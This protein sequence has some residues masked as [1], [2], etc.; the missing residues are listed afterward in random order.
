M[1]HV[2]RDQPTAP[3][4]ALAE[5]FGW[6]PPAKQVLGCYCGQARITVEGEP[7]MQFFCHCFS[8]RQWGGGPAQ[9]SK[10]YPIDKISV[11]GKLVMKDKNGKLPD[12]QSFRKSCANCGGVVFD[13]KTHAGMAMIPAGLWKDTVRKPPPR[14][15]PQRVAGAGSG[16]KY[17]PRRLGAHKSPPGGRVAHARRGACAATHTHPPCCAHSA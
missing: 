16:R 10:L 15:P 13:D 6:A 11:T 1:I 17:T 12:S 2:L 4:L 8:C 14:L 7:V 3:L 9:A 5:F